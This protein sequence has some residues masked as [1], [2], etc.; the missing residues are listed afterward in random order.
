MQMRIPELAL[1]ICGGIIGASVLAI[2]VAG[3]TI[4]EVRGMRR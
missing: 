4:R 1:A 2:L 3:M